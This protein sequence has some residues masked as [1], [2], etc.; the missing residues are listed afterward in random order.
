MLK[1]T[2]GLGLL[3]FVATM[4]EVYKARDPRLG[5]D[6]TIAVTGW[7]SQAVAGAELDGAHRAWRMADVAQERQGN[8]HGDWRVVE[9]AAAANWPA[10]ETWRGSSSTR[11]EVSGAPTD[12]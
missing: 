4:G 5:R 7:I 11:R 3:L 6:S 8:L 1:N 12:R 10:T 9:G 2:M